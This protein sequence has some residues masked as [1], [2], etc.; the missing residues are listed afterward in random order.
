MRRYVRTAIL[1]TIAAVPFWWLTMSL[2][3][4]GT[5]AG[6]KL[7]HFLAGYPAPHLL[8]E[9]D[10][11]YWFAPMFPPLAGLLLASDRLPMRR[12]VLSLVAGYVAFCYLVSLQI[13]VVWS[14]YLTLSA[15]RGYMSAVQVGLN[16]VVVPVI[17]WLIF[18]GGPPRIWSEVAV[19][20]STP[21]MAAHPKTIHSA[22]FMLL[23]CGLLTLPTML[24]AS[25]TSHNLTSAR[26]NLAASLTA[27]NTTGALSAIE[28][29]FQEQGNNAYLS[30]LQMQLLHEMGRHRDAEAAKNL[31][32][33][34]PKRRAAYRI[35]SL[36]HQP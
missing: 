36:Q 22:A 20:G 16:T 3:Q 26:D 21:P 8:A 28:A 14:P 1:Y 17:F 18:T 34:T 13:A 27:N 15:V 24:A 9:L 12:R 10:D 31:A 29:M 11:Y 35:Q 33:T 6:A 25:Q 5:I 32:L 19:A 4:H 7:L 2:A 23:F 30:Y